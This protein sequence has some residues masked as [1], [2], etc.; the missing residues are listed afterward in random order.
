LLVFGSST[1]LPAPPKAKRPA[2]AGRFAFA[3]NLQ[4]LQNLRN[5]ETL[6]PAKP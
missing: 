4:N 6:K 5:L 3:L 1:V 2:E